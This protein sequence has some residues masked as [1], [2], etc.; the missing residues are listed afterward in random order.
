[1][2][3]PALDEVYK[4]KTREEMIAWIS[5]PQGLKPG[6]AMP[7]IEMPAERRIEIVDYL[8]GLAR[9]PA[10]AAPLQPARPAVDPKD[11]E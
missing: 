11:F 8:L 9:T 1:M 4:R 6:T 2:V 7:K 5:D 3:G 10:T